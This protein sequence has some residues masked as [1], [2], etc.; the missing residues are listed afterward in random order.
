[1]KDKLEETGATATPQSADEYVLG[2]W[3]RRTTLFELRRSSLGVL[4][5]IDQGGGAF[6]PSAADMSEF[7][8]VEPGATLSSPLFRLHSPDEGEDSALLQLACA[9]AAAF[10]GL[11]LNN[12]Y[13][14]AALGRM[15]ARFARAALAELRRDPDVR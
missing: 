5:F 3:R 14:E 15:A 4:I 12:G 13:N 9:T 6:A 11:A 8:L 7:A 2:V 10:A 1:M